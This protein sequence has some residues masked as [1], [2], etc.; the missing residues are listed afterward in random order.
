MRYNLFIYVIA[1]FLIASSCKK[2]YP[3]AGLN[4]IR[5]SWN[6]DPSTTLTIGWD[7]FEG[8]NPVVHYG[9]RDKG[10]NWKRYQLSQEPTREVNH[11]GMNTRFCELSE[12]LPNTA[13]YFVIK[14]S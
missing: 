12:L 14:D 10:Q 9:T 4:K 7:Q 13:Y 5:L 11:L 2:E 3:P 1:L 8:E 6:D